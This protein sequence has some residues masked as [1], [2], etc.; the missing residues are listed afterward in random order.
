MKKEYDHSI[1]QILKDKMRS[2]NALID[3]DK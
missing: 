2:K 1:E 3:A